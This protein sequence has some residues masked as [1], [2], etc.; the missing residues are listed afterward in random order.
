MCVCSGH[1]AETVHLTHCQC[2][3]ILYFGTAIGDDVD[4]RCHHR[5]PHPQPSYRQTRQNLHN[6]VQRWANAH[7]VCA[8]IRIRSA[9]PAAAYDAQESR[10]IIVHCPH[11]RPVDISRKALTKYLSATNKYIYIHAKDHVRM[12][13]TIVYFIVRIT[14]TLFYTSDKLGI[15]RVGD[16]MVCYHEY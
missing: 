11:G 14:Q 15:S 6:I 2:V 1:S 16:E 4:D 7:C 8:W 10:I 13:Y 9:V 5:Q 12:I 3:Y